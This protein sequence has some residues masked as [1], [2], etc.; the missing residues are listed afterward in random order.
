L[1]T[2]LAIL[3]LPSFAAQAVMSARRRSA[4]QEMA[5]RRGSPKKSL[6]HPQTRLRLWQLADQLDCTAAGLR[7]G[8]EDMAGL[9]DD[10]ENQA[11]RVAKAGA[12]HRRTR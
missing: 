9:V 2:W 4:D 11:R 10:L 1:T 6:P 12:S 3:P 5:M 8:L 7:A